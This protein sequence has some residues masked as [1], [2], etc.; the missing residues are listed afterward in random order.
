LV[1]NLIPDELD[2]SWLWCPLQVSSNACYVSASGNRG[3]QWGWS[4]NAVSGKP[5]EA[6]REVFCFVFFFTTS[7]QPA[8]IRAA[9]V[10][11]RVLLP[12]RLLE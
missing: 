3:V 9:F 4:I 6:L 5:L 2:P 11:D 7:A 8:E 1:T 12:T 10:K